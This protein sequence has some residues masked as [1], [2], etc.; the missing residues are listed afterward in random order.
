MSPSNKVDSISTIFPDLFSERSMMRHLT[1]ESLIG[2]AHGTLSPE[3]KQDVEDHILNCA[4]CFA[5]ASDFLVV[6][7]QTSIESRTNF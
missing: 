4:L 3:D 5:E 2:L 1:I 6:E 7:L